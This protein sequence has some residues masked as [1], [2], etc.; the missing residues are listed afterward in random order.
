M[1]AVSPQSE[2]ITREGHAR[3][4]A[5]LDELRTVRRREVADALRDARADGGDAAEN[6]AVGETLDAAAALERR[7]DD[8]TASLATTLIADPP[9]PGVVDLGQR[10]LLR[11]STRATPTRYQLVGPLEADL[12][13]GRFSLDS[14]EGRAIAGRRAGDRVVVE[15]P[16]GS[17]TIEILEVGDADAAPAAPDSTPGG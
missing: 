11:F 13:A 8:L 12:A 14:P 10:V 17:R 5:E 4:I 6:H 3:L 2:P 16:G 15:T 7:I 1:F 9:R